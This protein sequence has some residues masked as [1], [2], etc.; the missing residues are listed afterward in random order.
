VDHCRGKRWVE[1]KTA[2]DL[3]KDGMSKKV[4]KKPSSNPYGQISLK[5][6]HRLTFGQF[7]FINKP[8]ELFKDEAS[9]FF[10]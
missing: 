3:E 10:E 8:L 4:S 2:F 7:T 5:R 6:Q 9:S 1:G